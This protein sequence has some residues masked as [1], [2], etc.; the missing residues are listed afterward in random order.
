MK[1]Q[2]VTLLDTLVFGVPALL[3]TVLWGLQIP[4][5]G[6]LL[7]AGLA[8]WL[9]YGT[10]LRA[11]W[12]L[13]HNINYVTKHGILVISRKLPV[14]QADVEAEVD[15]IV[16]SWEG[17][18]VP[19]ARALNGLVLFWMPF[20]DVHYSQPRFHRLG[21]TEDPDGIAVGYRADISKTR[22]AHELGHVF[23][24]TRQD[25]ELYAFT[26]THGLPR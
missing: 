21:L 25:S 9:A 7:F 26:K 23:L 1:I 13:V 12:K 6:F 15:R 5:G 4:F 20:P 19:T 3:M 10:I 17:V 16:S 18:G 8:F 24:G 14:M 2:V 22:L 11:R